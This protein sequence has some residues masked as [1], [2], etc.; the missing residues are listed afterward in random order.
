M[1]EDLSELD[2][3]RAARAAAA[4]RCD[5]H[6]EAMID[7]YAANHAARRQGFVRVEA[8]KAAKEFELAQLQAIPA[9]DRR[10]R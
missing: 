6:F 9:A 7:G 2:K 10:R 1:P 5:A 8:E 3:L 4:A